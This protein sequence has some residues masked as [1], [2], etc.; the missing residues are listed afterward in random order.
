MLPDYVADFLEMPLRFVAAVCIF[1]VLFFY[2]AN[3]FMKECS[4]ISQKSVEDIVKDMEAQEQAAREHQQKLD[5]AL[6]DVEAHIEA[7]AEQQAQ[8]AAC[9]NLD[10]RCE[11]AHHKQIAPSQDLGTAQQAV[12][13]LQTTTA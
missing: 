5:K 9:A 1:L 7:R 4:D 11:T 12:Q 3:R 6:A 8:Q 10:A 2:I 13:P